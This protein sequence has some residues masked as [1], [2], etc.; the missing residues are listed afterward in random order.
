LLGT[1]VVDLSS[2]VVIR[3]VET[4]AYM[5]G[6]PASHS[7]R[8]Q[9]PRN[10]AMFG[11]AGHW[12]VYFT[13]GMHWCLNVVTGD[14]GSGQAV[15]VRAGEVV[16]G[17]ST[18]RTRRGRTTNS[19]K[20]AFTLVDGPAKLAQALGVSKADNGTSTTPGVGRLHLLHSDDPAPLDRTTPR[21]GISKAI[22]V[23]WRFCTVDAPRRLPV[24]RLAGRPTP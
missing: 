11:P 12:Y 24:E 9:T 2:D 13:Y 19:P 3:I 16:A 1:L 14:P 8:G 22:E 21:I 5:P 23:P 4:E 10:A 18:V 17:L 7:F 15:L 20:D 6:D